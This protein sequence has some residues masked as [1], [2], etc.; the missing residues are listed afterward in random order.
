ME[1]KKN[2]DDFKKNGILKIENFIPSKETIIIEKKIISELK[3][4]KILNNGKFSLKKFEGMSTFQQITKI[5]QLID[6]KDELE[7]LF[8]KKLESLINKVAEK[9]FIRSSPQLLLTLPSKEEWSLNNLNWH[10]DIK[11]TKPYPYTS[12]IQIFIL[13]S[14]L[15]PNGGATLAL[16]GSHKLKRIDI[17]NFIEKN[18][19]NL[20]RDSLFKINDQ[21]VTIIEMT[22]KA[23]D[24]YLMNTSLIHSP[25]INASNTLRIMATARYLA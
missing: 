20:K 11:P 14:D 7:K 19:S 5:S 8:E 2:I 4:L 10:L 23:G 17:Q 3:K 24:I 13:L 9:K 21:E 25:S 6:I 22:G 18:S 12:G 1:V 16:A 15:F